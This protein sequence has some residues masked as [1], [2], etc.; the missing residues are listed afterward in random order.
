MLLKR[1]T[2]S[3]IYEPSSER[4]NALMIIVKSDD[5][6]AI[7]VEP[8]KWGEACVMKIHRINISVLSP[9][10]PMA[11]IFCLDEAQEWG[12]QSQQWAAGELREDEWHW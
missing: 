7:P 6:P 2:V 5:D 9:P 11:W 4:K 12:A 10:K 3:Y 8:R 1:K